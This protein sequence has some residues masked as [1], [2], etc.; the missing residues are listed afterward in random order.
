MP[1]ILI[2]LVAA[3]ELLEPECLEIGAPTDL[4][5]VDDHGEEVDRMEFETGYDAHA[6]LLKMLNVQK[7]LQNG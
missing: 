6:Y 2:R 5:W 4:V 7:E 1:T 3:G